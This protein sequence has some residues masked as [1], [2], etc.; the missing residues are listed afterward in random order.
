MANGGKR[1]GSGRKPDP[2]EIKK[3]KASITLRP[4]LL[5][6]LDALAEA[7]G[8]SRARCIESA[9]EGFVGM[10]GNEFKIMRMKLDGVLRAAGVPAPRID[11]V[12]REFQAKCPDASLDLL[13]DAA[14]SFEEA[15]HSH[16]KIRAAQAEAIEI[17]RNFSDFGLYRCWRAGEW[18]LVSQEDR[19]FLDFMRAHDRRPEDV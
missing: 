15:K 13:H 18:F 6:R 19:H 2:V 1:A 4:D 3:V 12:V 7:Q 17:I 16:R 8:I 10:E 9:I 14:I 11:A 5:A